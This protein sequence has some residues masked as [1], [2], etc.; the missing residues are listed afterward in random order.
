MKTL[1][2]PSFTNEKF[3]YNSRRIEKVFELTGITRYRVILPT[4]NVDEEKWPFR[5]ADYADGCRAL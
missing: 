1:S 4:V 2:D 5:F 3:Y